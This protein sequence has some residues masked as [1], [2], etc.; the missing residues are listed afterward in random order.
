MLSIETVL[1]PTDCSEASAAAVEYAV[2]V[3]DRYGASLHLL[4]VLDERVVDGL[5]T[6]DV[7][8]EAVAAEYQEFAAEVEAQVAESA[9]VDGFTH[10]SAA[11]FSA[12][13]LRRSPGSVVLDAAD[14]VDADFIVIP[15]ETP[16]SS[17]AETIGK[18]ALYVVEY[19]SQPVLSV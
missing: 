5:E 16:S 17:A 3:A 18:A 13:S 7:T 9:D 4:Q 6:G 10:S 12:R 11:G 1:A 2:A 14:E 15:R 8:A 19:A